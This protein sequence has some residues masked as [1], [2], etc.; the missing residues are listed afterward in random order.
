M[1]RAEPPRRRRIVAMTAAAALAVAGAL[2]AA[3]A[4]P[5]LKTSSLQ[6]TPSAS[7][8]QTAIAQGLGPAVLKNATAQGATPPSTFELVSFILRGRNMFELASD[9]ESGRSPT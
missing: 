6:T 7:L 3:L 8:G 4:D 1:K 5:P 2:A 9:V